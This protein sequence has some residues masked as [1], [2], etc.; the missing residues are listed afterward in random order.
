MKFRESSFRYF[1]EILKKN[2]VYTGTHMPSFSLFQKYFA[3][4]SNIKITKYKGA[5]KRHI[6]TFL[7]E[8]HLRG[9]SHHFNEEPFPWR[10]QLREN[11]TQNLSPEISPLN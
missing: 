9:K 5:E 1:K 4:G 2:G 7:E 6:L 10:L 3:T 8:K 11:F